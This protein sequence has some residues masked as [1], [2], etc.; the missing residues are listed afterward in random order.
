MVS[1]NSTNKFNKYPGALFV[2]LAF[3]FLLNIAEFVFEGLRYL[4]Y[5][6]TLILIITLILKRP[7]KGKN[8]NYFILI[9]SYF[10]VLIVRGILKDNYLPYTLNDIYVWSL[11]VFILFFSSPFSLSYY[12]I[13]IPE[14]F[15]KLLYF[16]LPFTLIII[17]MHGSFDSNITTRQ[18]VGGNLNEKAIYQPLLLS[19]LLMPFVSQFRK[20]LRYIVIL[21]NFVLLLLGVL[22][23]TR[24]VFIV[25]LFGFFSLL[26]MRKKN[27]IS[28][29]IT[30][31]AIV[32]LLIYIGSLILPEKS[33]AFFTDK[34]DYLL[35]RFEM[36]EKI[37]SGRDTEFIGLFTNF[38]TL[39]FILGRGAGGS[40][41]FGF[42]E[43]IGTVG[44]LGV[45]FT[46]F[47]FLNLIL[48]GGFPLLI[49]VY[50]LAIWSMVF[51]WRKG[52]R[53][54]S[55]VILFF[56]IYEISHTKFNDPFYMIFLWV[57]I[58]YSLQLS[59]VSKIKKRN[60]QSTQ[61]TI[62]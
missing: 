9:L 54:Y 47:G 5:F 12:R 27:R 60:L 16:A 11:C 15:A 31:F 58:S 7:L 55:F 30:S 41:A 34:F 37:T 51:L 32:V 24:V 62:N 46:H 2:I 8:F 56:L 23:A 33:T 44:N 10:I 21:S 42:W 22:S 17:V 36:G 48:K 61:N 38:S 3:I 35:S 13:R 25:P 57:S 45:P 14:L 43:Q 52:K 1:N 50:G 26:F 40:Q 39:E 28:K 18:I 53:E 4:Q 19:P 20:N 6:L 59:T 49:L 29:L